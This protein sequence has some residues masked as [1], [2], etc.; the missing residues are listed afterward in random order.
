VDGHAPRAGL[1]HAMGRA[2][3]RAG[4]TTLYSILPASNQ[5]QTANRKPKLDERTPRH[6]IR[7]NKYGPT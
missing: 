1:G 4:L 2:R 7:Q 3:P 6:K 5:D